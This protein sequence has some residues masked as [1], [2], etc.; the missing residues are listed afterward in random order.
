LQKVNTPIT[1][2]QIENRISNL[3]ADDVS[4]FA[5]LWCKAVCKSNC[6][7]QSKSYVFYK[8]TT[9]TKILIK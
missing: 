4:N 9:L 3:L 5:R 1:H 7:M 6:I 2:Q 8:Q